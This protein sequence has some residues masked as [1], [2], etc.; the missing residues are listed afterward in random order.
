ME[1]VES[2]QKE[3]QMSE[4]SQFL[5]IVYGERRRSHTDVADRTE[6]IASSLS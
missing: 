6:R 5:G 4:K 2:N 3:K 1:R